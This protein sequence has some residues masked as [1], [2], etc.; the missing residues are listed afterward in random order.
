MGVT[1]CVPV[2]REPFFHTTRTR[3]L[4]HIC[5]HQA[6]AVAERLGCRYCHCLAETAIVGLRRRHVHHKDMQYCTAAN[7]NAQRPSI[8]S[9]LQK[10]S[11]VW[12]TTNC[13][14]SETVHQRAIAKRVCGAAKSSYNTVVPKQR[15]C[16][17]VGS[18]R[19]PVEPERTISPQHC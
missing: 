9:P 8:N 2:F 11:V 19:A 5:Q 13:C 10:E 7:Q 14:R 1:V 15:V 6:D 17:T 16:S 18:H 3:V 12:Q 4:P